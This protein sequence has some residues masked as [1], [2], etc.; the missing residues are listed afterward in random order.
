MCLSGELC[1]LFRVRLR[2]EGTMATSE[3]S[4]KQ[5]NRNEGLVARRRAAA[6]D[7][8]GCEARPQRE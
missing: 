6:K 3:R 8:S 2:M 1:R 4:G 5:R 7:K